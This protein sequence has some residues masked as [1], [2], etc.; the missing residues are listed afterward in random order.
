GRGAGWSAPWSGRSGR[1]A[2]ARW[3][4]RPGTRVIPAPAGSRGRGDGDDAGS[5]SAGPAN[6]S[7]RGA[8]PCEVLLSGAGQNASTPGE[9]WLLERDGRID[10]A[11]VRT[12]RGRGRE[13]VVGGWSGRTPTIRNETGSAIR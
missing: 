9:K 8:M 1:A 7:G 5:W 11:A 13:G 6:S 10:V 3:R 2:E 4:G 12:R